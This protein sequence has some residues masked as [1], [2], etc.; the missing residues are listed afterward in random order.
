MSSS[1]SRNYSLNTLLQMEDPISGAL[2][3]ITAVQDFSAVIG[4][5]A[6]SALSSGWDV[7]YVHFSQRTIPAAELP[8]I[9]TADIDLSR[10]YEHFTTAVYRLI[11]GSPERTLFLFD[12]LSDLQTAWATDLMMVNFF[13]VIIPALSRQHCSAHFP[14]IRGMH[15]DQALAVLQQHSDLFLNLY[16]DFKYIYVR[17]EATATRPELFSGSV[18]GDSLSQPHVYRPENK[19]FAPVSEGVLLSKFHRALELSEKIN[20]HQRMDSWDRFFAHARS[21][22]EFGEDLTDDC[23][24]MCRIMM[25]R[26]PRMRRLIQENFTP[27]DYS[28]SRSTWSAQVSSEAKPAAC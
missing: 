24:R 3:C 28:L 17:P 23:A 10:S 16:A 7:V 12:C 19:Q 22:Y 26:D 25:S 11:L 9:R 15:S 13:R 18:L 27:E 1:I 20:R 8:G 21:K 5:L 2:W 4:P 14:L 6:E